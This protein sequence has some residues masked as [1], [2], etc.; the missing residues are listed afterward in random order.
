[1]SITPKDVLALTQGI[2]QDLRDA[3]TA[4]RRANGKFV[5][6]RSWLSS[7]PEARLPASPYVCP[8]CGIDTR[9]PVG[10]G[11]H[12][13]NVHALMATAKLANDHGSVLT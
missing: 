4:L 8:Q 5:S 6:L 12:L 7:L 10:L 13:A 2:Q 3:E 11:D 1:M 9:G